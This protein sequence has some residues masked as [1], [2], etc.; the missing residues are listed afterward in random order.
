MITNYNLFEFYTGPYKAAGFKH[1]QEEGFGFVINTTESGI[2][3]FKGIKEDF[4]Q[5]IAGL[6]FSQFQV[7]IEKAP[8]S[9]NPFKDKQKYCNI[10][11][12][13]TA[14]NQYEAMSIISEFKNYFDTHEIII[15]RV[16]M[17]T[18]ITSE[19]K[20][21]ELFANLKDIT[22]YVKRKEIEKQMY[23]SNMYKNTN[24]YKDTKIGFK[25][26]K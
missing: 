25:G 22:S 17:R 20:P 3:K 26:E 13:F 12:L 10:F 4:I 5:Y 19:T 2:K 18:G 24:A 6:G 14:I 11:L 21:E 9:F 7:I 23:G 1:F 8:S 15:N 16:S